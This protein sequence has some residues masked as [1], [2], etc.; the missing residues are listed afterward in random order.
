MSTRRQLG[1]SRVWLRWARVL[2]VAILT[3]CAAVAGGGTAGAQ[4]TS[5]GAEVRPL[6]AYPPGTPGPF[7]IQNPSTGLCLDT[8]T[9][10]RIPVYMGRC[11]HTDPGQRWGWFNG[12]WLINLTTGKCVYASYYDTPVLQGSCRYTSNDYWTHRNGAIVNSR[13]GTCLI[14]QN[15]GVRVPV[16]GCLSI[17]RQVWS[18]TYW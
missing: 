11:N 5:S 14:S 9:D 2:V 6:A 7:K 3:L 17:P 10:G 16:G 8:Y 15:E 18:V 4:P 13:Y 12:G 1:A